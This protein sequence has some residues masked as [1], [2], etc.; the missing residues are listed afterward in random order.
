MFL[1]H[2][3]RELLLSVRCRHDWVNT[4]IFFVMVTSLLPLATGSELSSLSKIAGGIIW[5]TALLA[6][7]L[8]LDQL[9]R[10]DYE[11]GVLDQMLL[12]PHG[13]FEP[14]MAKIIIHWLIT[15]LPL[16]L[17]SP[18]LAI[19]FGMSNDVAGFVCFSL[20]AGTPYFSCV[21]AI[22]AALTVSLRKSGLIPSLIVMPLYIPVLILG[23]GTVG[24]V[25]EGYNPY[26]SLLI[27]GALSV[28]AF[29]LSPFAIMFA[30]RISADG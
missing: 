17:V 4:L 2:I 3:R 12:S 11:D 1:R 30:L 13:L 15:G 20:A 27:V 28:F 23:A 25:I 16:T 5:I 24:Q 7:L 9:F 14:V 6:T 21:G 8:S 22:G 10:S 18:V 26:G 19:M 29:V